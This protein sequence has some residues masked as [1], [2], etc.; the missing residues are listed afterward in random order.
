[1][2][3]SSV[4]MTIVSITVGVLLIGS[5]MLPQITDL[6]SKLSDDKTEANP[7]GGH[8]DWS[9][10]L[11]VLVICTMIGLIAVALYAFKSKN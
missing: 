9:N 4:V 10:M 5:L 2:D 3:V 7:L 8:E 11:G 1:M 6:M